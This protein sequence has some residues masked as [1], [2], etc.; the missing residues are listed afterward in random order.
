MKFLK[1]LVC[2]LLAAALLIPVFGTGPI[3]AASETAKNGSRVDFTKDGV[4]YKY[5][6]QGVETSRVDVVGYVGDKA[7]VV[8][9]AYIDEHRVYGI[10][11]EAFKDNTTI[12]SIELPDSLDNIYIDAFRDCV[13]LKKVTFG[14]LLKPF[15]EQGKDVVPSKTGF[16]LTI[17]NTAFYGCTSLEEVVFAGGVYPNNS[18]VTEG[19]FAKSGIKKAT[20]YFNYA[21]R[22]SGLF[23]GADKLEVLDLY[24]M[25]GDYKGDTYLVSC[26]DMASLTEINIYDAEYLMPDFHYDMGEN[27]NTNRA[28][29]VNCPKLKTVNL[30]Y[31]ETNADGQPIADQHSSKPD[32]DCTV[33][34]MSYSGGNLPAYKNK[35]F[36]AVSSD[37]SVVKINSNGQRS[38]MT[39]VGPGEATITYKDMPMTLYV[40]VGA[41]KA[42]KNIAD[43]KITM[44]IDKAPYTGSAVNPYFWI[45]DGKTVLEKDKDYTVEIKDNIEIGTGTVTVTG[46]GDYT[47]TITKTFEIDPVTVI[48]ESVTIGKK[49]ST[50]VLN[51]NKQADG[52]QIYYSSKKNKGFKKLYSGTDTAAKVTKLK[53][54]MYIKVRTYKKVGKTTYYSEWSAPIQVK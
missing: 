2:L 31:D 28:S 16:P 14:N 46:K 11:R 3:F 32:S 53:S 44:P 33:P 20:V 38:D 9:P 43:A 35:T 7:E 13:N 19:I 37:E 52:Y 48:A 22:V 12:T 51:K 5:W 25:K 18:N 29:F 15:R 30:Y 17:H 41:G 21:T 34:F 47:G 45:A 50:I 8:I 54:G 23:E 26:A 24:A 42:K 36:I 10:G 4:Q 49:E 39:L 1:K 6:A 27:Y 40:H